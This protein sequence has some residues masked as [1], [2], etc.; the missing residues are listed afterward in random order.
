M[1]WKWVGL[2]QKGILT[3][4]VLCNVGSQQLNIQVV[5]VDGP[6]H[7]RLVEEYLL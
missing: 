4:A 5:V 6:C 2:I 1:K 7:E 3:L